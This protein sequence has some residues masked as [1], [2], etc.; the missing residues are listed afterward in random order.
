MP[1]VEPGRGRL[2]AAR[3]LRPAGALLVVAGLL[4]G[5]ANRAVYDSG[6]FAQRAASALADPRVAG[7]LAERAADELIARDRDLMAY[8]PLIVGAARLLVASDTFRAVFQSGVARAHAAALSKGAEQVYLSLPD[9]AVL[10]R[11]ALPRLPPEL[12]ARLPRG[13]GAQLGPDVQKTLGVWAVQVLRATGRLSRYTLACLLAGTLLLAG[14]VA[15]Q[16]DRR[17]AILST[18]LVLA[19]AALALLVVSPLLGLVL[20]ARI[21]DPPLRDAARG[22][23]DAFAGP[24]RSWALVLLAMGLVLS[25]AASSLASHVEVEEAV[26]ACWSWLQRPSPRRGLELARALALVGVGVMGALDP[27]AVVRLLTVLISAALAFEGLRA[28]FALVAPR[29]DGGGPGHSLAGSEH[30]ASRRRH[31]WRYGLLGAI[32]LALLAAG[33]AW[34]RSPAALPRV[35]FQ[36]RCNGSEALCGRT[37]DQVVLAGAHNAM[38]AADIPGW[39]FPNQEQGIPAQLRH[40]VRALLIDVHNGVPVAGRIKTVLEHEPSSRAKFEQALGAEAVAAAMRIRDRLVGPPEGPEG[41]YLC[42]GFCEL[43]AQPLLPLLREIR[44]FV[45]TNP[46]EV[47]LIDIE[48]Y[49]PPATIAQAFEQSGLVEHVFRGR[50]GPPWPTLRQMVEADQRVLVVAENDNGGGRVP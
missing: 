18:G 5:Y 16:G 47:L 21:P 39:M 27:G 13:V 6:A 44:E 43:G 37:F 32:A 35:A 10:L 28:V 3:A 36:G 14:S 15:L 42:H 38:A 12:A 45:L 41:A 31:R 29:I 9:L 40:G 8:R 23:W 33:V 20:E 2:Q 26:G 7:Y 1:T 46:G 48:D 19:G 50:P 4:L 24:L 22:V 30:P 11:S 34:L 17:R 49:V 25:A